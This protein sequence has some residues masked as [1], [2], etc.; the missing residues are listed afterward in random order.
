MQVPCRH[1]TAVFP[2]D[3]TYKVNAVSETLVQTKKD[4]GNNLQDVKR[5]KTQLERTLTVTPSA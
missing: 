5:P 3:M 4:Y 2:R 1:D